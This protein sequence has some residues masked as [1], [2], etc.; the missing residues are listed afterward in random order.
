MQKNPLQKRFFVG[1]SSPYIYIYAT[2]RTHLVSLRARCKHARS[3]WSI[4][5]NVLS[6]HCR[7]ATVYGHTTTAMNDNEYTPPPSDDG[8][9]PC[10]AFARGAEHF[11]LLAPLDSDRISMTTLV[12]F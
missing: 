2:R 4:K 10:V 11:F 8:Y 5:P 3:A 7:G 6:R 1:C 12:V 9:A